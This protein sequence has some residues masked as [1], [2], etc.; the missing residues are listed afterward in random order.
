MYIHIYIW[1]LYSDFEKSISDEDV[2]E[3]FAI[4]PIQ[5]SISNSLNSISYEVAAMSEHEAM[6][7]SN[8]PKKS[9]YLSNLCTKAMYIG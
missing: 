5:D 4:K 7:C 3:S 8:C 1:I 6:Q 9:G 2:K